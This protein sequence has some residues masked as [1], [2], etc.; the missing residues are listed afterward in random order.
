MGIFDM[1]KKKGS[2]EDEMGFADEPFPKLDE[3]G[4]PGMDSPLGPPL[5]LDMTRGHGDERGGHEM[6][7]TGVERQT[8]SSPVHEAMGPS[9]GIQ[10]DIS[11][12]LELISA[13]LDT[14]K[15]LVE[16]MNH[17]LKLIEDLARGET[18]TRK[19]RW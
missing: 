3:G 9:A 1:F 5:G 2:F 10:R 16:N 8:Y 18:D 14:L 4:R 11:K 17:R 13:K 15:A 6:P 19:D 7:F 12:D